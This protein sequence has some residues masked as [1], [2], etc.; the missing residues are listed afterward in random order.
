MSLQI[1]KMLHDAKSQYQHV[2]VFKSKTWGNVLVLDGVIQLT[3][4]DECAYQGM[5]RPPPHIPT[6]PPYRLLIVASDS[7][8]QR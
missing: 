5:A 7:A 3:E 4:K 2:V 8:R 6:S 1:E